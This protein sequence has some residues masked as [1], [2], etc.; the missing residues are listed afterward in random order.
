[1]PKMGTLMPK[2]PNTLATCL[3]RVS[4]NRILEHYLEKLVRTGLYGNNATEAAGI[5]IS[6]EIERLI[7]EK[8]IEPAPKSVLADA[9]NAKAK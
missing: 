4:G 5:L 6:R 1:M 8:F 2:P 3:L 7:S 9:A